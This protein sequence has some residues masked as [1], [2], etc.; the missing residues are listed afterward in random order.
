M[1]IYNILYIQ[2]K[3][4][5]ISNQVADFLTCGVADFLTCGSSKRHSLV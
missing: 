2:Y 3:Y 1:A 5:H 4:S